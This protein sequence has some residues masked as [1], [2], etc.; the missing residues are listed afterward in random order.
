MPAGQTAFDALRELLV[1]QQLAVVATQMREVPYTSLVAFAASDDLREIVFATTRAT[2][3]YRNLSANPQVS[4]L[5][6]SR[7]HSIEDFSTGTAATAVGKAAE[8]PAG[9]AVAAVGRFVAKHPHLEGFATSPS[10][11]MCRIEVERY[12]LVTRFQHVVE[13]DVSQWSS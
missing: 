11:A 5:V 12:Y 7:T 2:T 3:K 4:V 13:L 10:T 9:E 6:D 1:S 8:I